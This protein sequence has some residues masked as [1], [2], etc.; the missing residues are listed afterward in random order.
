MSRFDP[1]LGHH[2][3][4]YKGGNQLVA[5]TTFQLPMIPRRLLLMFV[6]V[7]NHGRVP[8]LSSELIRNEQNE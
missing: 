8:I 2:L 4:S 1:G 5:P 6:L 7:L 3:I